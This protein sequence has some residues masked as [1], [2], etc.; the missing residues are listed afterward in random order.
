MQLLQAKGSTAQ[1]RSDAGSKLTGQNPTAQ[2][3][4]VDLVVAKRGQHHEVAVEFAQILGAL[5]R[6]ELVLVLDHRQDELLVFVQH[7]LHHVC[8]QEGLRCRAVLLR[9]SFPLHRTTRPALCS[10]VLGRAK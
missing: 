7:T 1:R 9:L 6:L 2:T 8:R 10:R 3:R 5:V 4:G